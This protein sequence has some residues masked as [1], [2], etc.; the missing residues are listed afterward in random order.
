MRNFQLGLREREPNLTEEGDCDE[1][2]GSSFGR[3]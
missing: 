3:P 1:L 2:F